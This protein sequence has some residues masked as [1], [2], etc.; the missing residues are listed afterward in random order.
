MKRN[1]TTSVLVVKNRIES[2]AKKTLNI[3]NK[4]TLENKIIFEYIFLEFINNLNNISQG[5]LIKTQDE[6]TKII[7]QKINEGQVDVLGKD[8]SEEEASSFS[9]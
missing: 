2:S 8:N 7:E 1:A 6:K 4:K 9:T 3:V 5:D